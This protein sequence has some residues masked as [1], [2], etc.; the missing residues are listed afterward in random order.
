MLVGGNIGYQPAAS[1]SIVNGNIVLSA[2]ANVATTGNQTDAGF[3][4]DK[5]AADS[6]SN[7]EFQNA[8]FGSS[9]STFATNGIVATTSSVSDSIV[10]NG[11]T[12]TQN[13]LLEARNQIDINARGGGIIGANGNVTLRAGSDGVGGTININ[14][15]QIGF[16]DLIISGL[17][18]NGNLIVDASAS[19]RDDFSTVRNNGGTGIGQ[20]AVGGNINIDINGGGDLV[21]G[22]TAQ[23]NARAQGG[24][25]EIQ[26]G[27][28]QG[29]NIILNVSSGT[30]NVTGTT[31]FD[32]E[33]IDAQN[34]KIGGNGPGLV[35]SDSVGGDISLNLSGGAVTTGEIVFSQGATA[36]SG[37]AAGGAQS[38]DATAGALDLTV[39]GGTHVIDNIEVY[40]TAASEGSFDAAG[41]A[42]SG[43]ASSGGAHFLIDGGSLT[44]SSDLQGEL[45]T[46]GVTPAASEDRVTITVQNAGS[47]QV[48]GEINISTRAFHGSDSVT[49]TGGGISILADNATL[50]AGGIF[51][52]TSAQPN[53]QFFSNDPSEGKDFQAGDINIAARNGGAITAGFSFLDANATGNDTIAGN[54]TGGDILIEAN[55]GSIEFTDFLGVNA[56][57]VGGVGGD[58]DIPDSLGTGRGGAVTFRVQGTSGAMTLS[59]LD[60]ASDGSI[61]VGGEGGAPRFEGDGG[62]GFGGDVTFDLLGGTFLADDITV[63]SNGSGGGG[64]DLFTVPGPVTNNEAAVLAAPEDLTLAVTPFAGGVSAGDGGDGQGGDVTFNLNGGNATVTNLT[65]SANG[66]GGDGANGDINY[67]T[68][69]GSGGRGLGGNTTFNAIAGNLTVTSTLTVAAEGNIQNAAP[70]GSRGAG[71]FGYGSDGGNG[72][73]G[74]GGTA[75]FNLDGSATINASN[76][77]VSTNAEGGYGAAVSAPAAGPSRPER[78]AVAAMQ[79][80]AMQSSTI[81]RVRSALASFRSH[82]LAPAERAATSSVSRPVKRIISPVTVAPGAA[83]MRPSTS[84]RMISAVRFISSTPAA[85]AAMAV[86]DWTAETAAQLLAGLQRSMSI[87]RRLIRMI[88]R[89]SPAQLAE[90]AATGCGMRPTISRAIVAMAEARP[91]ERRVWKS[92]VPAGISPSASSFWKPMPPVATG[93]MVSISSAAVWTAVTADRAVTRRAAQSN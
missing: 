51:L 31:F 36:S 86:M 80:A 21:V 68:A 32:S 49:S 47:L 89:S 78:A 59:D 85:S 91:V 22:G 12:G 11:P 75:T 82:R 24:K 9:V 7:I 46:F 60:I 35:G 8:A 50:T 14:A 13:L 23:F 87:M 83:A 27:S 84:I 70:Y 43:N 77:V 34:L 48:N 57:G 88:R 71:G 64:G 74:I 39:T 33:A 81:M 41:T 73:D 29:G 28:A 44:I 1:A 93:R 92:L 38:N 56:S 17:I 62:L 54:A 19:G 53:D 16:G 45:N 4:F 40:A 69:G 72:G 58:D 66:F 52:D 63:G 18:A 15:D 25:G 10:A 79:R 6:N 37:A 65:I 67:G 30:F 90:T 76:I 3:A 5:K 2:G 55:D 61:S 20:D 42:I 26:N